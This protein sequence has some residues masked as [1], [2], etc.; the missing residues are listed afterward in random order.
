MPTQTLQK[1]EVTRLHLLKEGTINYT[2][3]T[4]LTANQFVALATVDISTID[5]NRVQVFEYAHGDQS[6][7][8]IPNMGNV[9]FISG[10]TLVLAYKIVRGTVTIGFVCSGAGFTPTAPFHTIVGGYYVMYY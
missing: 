5:V 8:V 4:T 2:V 3:N 9:G 6:T 1:P 10:N 7:T